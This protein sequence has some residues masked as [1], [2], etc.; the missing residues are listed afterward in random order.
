MKPNI[1]TIILGG[2]Q[3]TRLYPLTELRSKPAVPIA[4][5]YRLVD[6]PI[7]NC[8][9][10]GFNRIMVL[11]QF[12][13]ASLN[14]HIKNAYHFDIFSRGFVEILAADQDFDSKSWFQGTADAVRKSMKH[15][16]RFSYDYL[17]IL[18]GDQLYRM[19]YQN[20]LD[21]H[22]KSNAE[23]S[24]ATIPVDKQDAT[25][26]GILKSDGESKITAFVEKPDAE[27]LTDWKSNVSE[28]NL[29]SGREYLASMGIYIFNRNVLNRIFQEDEGDDFGKEL[30][31]RAIHK[32]RT[33]SYQFDG[34]WTDIG[35]IRSFFDANM[36]L[37]ADL[38]QFNLYG[39]DKIYTNSRMLPPNKITGTKISRTLFGGGAIVSAKELESSVIGVRSRID[40]GSIVKRT[41]IMGADYFSKNEDFENYLKYGK[42]LLG[43]GENCYV[44]NAIIDKNCRIGNNVTIRGS[45][46]LEDGD[47][48][49][50]TITD[51]IIILK[52][53]AVIPAG[54]VIGKPRDEN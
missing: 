24:I 33:I 49:N 9:N 38:P 10:S 44:E 7:S 29:E 2:G 50:H 13:S 30:I 37:T 53:Y 47:F 17:L 5:K 42:P 21:F 25:G 23:I 27:V 8:L 34:Y 31:P 20:M 28:K 54:T 16:H 15:L 35:T 14:S 1:L 52:K 19:D 32:Y 46:D 36:D 39:P 18:S 43:I 51:G 45:K 6:I 4:G 11:T 26:F 40:S 3:G 41:Y 48:D 12:N 22:K